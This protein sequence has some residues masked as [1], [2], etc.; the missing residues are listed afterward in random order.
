MALRKRVH[1]RVRWVIMTQVEQVI[2]YM[3][4]IMESH[5]WMLSMSSVLQG[6]QHVSVTLKSRGTRSKAPQRSLMASIIQGIS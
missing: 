6:L 2:A 1:H 3:E 4:R 5:Q